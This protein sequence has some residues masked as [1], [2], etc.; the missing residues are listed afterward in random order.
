MKKYLILCFVILLALFVGFISLKSNVFIDKE[1]DIYVIALDDA[2]TR[3]KGC[4]GAEVVELGNGSLKLGIER[5]RALFER[6]IGA[7]RLYGN[8]GIQARKFLM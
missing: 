5:E 1:N 3:G 8:V 6:K 4:N 2:R 7:R